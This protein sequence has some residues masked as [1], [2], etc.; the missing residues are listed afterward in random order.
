MCAVLSINNRPAIITSCYILLG[1]LKL[2]SSVICQCLCSCYR[3]L[4]YANIKEAVL[5]LPPLHHYGEPYLQWS[6]LYLTWH[7]S[8]LSFQMVLLQWLTVC[9]HSISSTVDNLIYRCIWEIKLKLHS[10]P[11]GFTMVNVVKVRRL[12][13]TVMIIVVKPAL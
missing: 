12:V 7:D 1:N 9:L 2:F 4:C 6:Q 13:T 10:C 8:P 5:T 11:G 3:L